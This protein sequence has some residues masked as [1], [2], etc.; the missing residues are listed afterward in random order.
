MRKKLYICCYDI[1][2]NK[3]RK[4]VLTAVQKQQV[5]GQYSAYECYL[6]LGQKIQF[7]KHL[8]SLVD[9]CD[10]VKLQIIHDVSNIIALGVARAPV[11]AEYM[12]FG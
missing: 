7:E 8:N 9:E 5:G 12:Y 3:R 4:K 6:T 10:T 1:S 2:C 11:N